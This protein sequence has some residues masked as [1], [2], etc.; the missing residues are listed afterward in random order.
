[1][2]Q[3]L[4]EFEVKMQMTSLLVL[5]SSMVHKTR[6]EKANAWKWENGLCHFWVCKKVSSNLT[7]E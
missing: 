6:G 4:A 2:Q 1:M 5:D 7:V 3:K